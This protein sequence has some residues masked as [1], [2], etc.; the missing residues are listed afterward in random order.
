M[1]TQHLFSNRATAKLAVDVAANDTALTLVPGGGALFP[2]PGA[3]QYF[4]LVLQKGTAAT[5]LREYMVCTA[6]AGD[7]LTVTRAQEG[8]PA[9]TFN[10]GDEVS[11]VAT[12]ATFTSLVQR[13]GATLQGA[14]EVEADPTTPLGIATKAFVES[15]RVNDVPDD[16]KTYGRVFQAWLALGAAAGLPV[17]IPVN[18]G[19]TGGATVAA[20]QT[21]LYIPV[22]TFDDLP[23]ATPKYGDR[24]IRPANMTEMVW[25]PNAGG[26][27]AGI[28]INPAD[29]ASEA[30]PIPVSKGGT[31]ATT[32][33]QALINLGIAD[34]DSLRVGLNATDMYVSITAKASPGHAI[35]SITKG[36]AGAAGIYGYNGIT[37]P[38]PRWFVQLGD[39]GVESGSNAGSNFGIT[40]YNDAGAAI[41]SPFSIN[42][43]S[44]VASFGQS[45][46]FYGG[47]IFV[48]S[49]AANAVLQLDKQLAANASDIYGSIN[50]TVR[51]LLRLGQ[52]GGTD[53]FSII[54]YNDAG[55]YT[56]T[57]MQARRSDGNIQFPSPA[58]INMAGTLN[59][60]KAQA[61]GDSLYAAGPIVNTGNSVN[62][63]YSAAGGLSVGGPGYVGGQFTAG[64]GMG[65]RY[66]GGS[67]NFL[68]MGS[69]HPS[70]WNW[71]WNRSSGLLY[72]LNGASVGVF[73]IDGN[74]NTNIAGT[75]TMGASIQGKDGSG[76]A[77]GPSDFYAVNSAGYRIL[78]WAGGYC[79]RWRVAN[80]DLEWIA[81]NASV[82][83]LNYQGNIQFHGT[84]AATDG[85]I[86][87]QGNFLT[88]AT[89]GN[90]NGN[91]FSN[92]VAGSPGGMYQCVSLQH[93]P[94]VSAAVQ[95]QA[96]G[97]SFS[98]RSDGIG[99][100]PGGWQTSDRATKK[101]IKALPNGA[102]AAVMAIP[103]TE[104][105]RIAVD[106]ATGKS[107]HQVGWVAQD[108]QPVFARAVHT[109]RDWQ[110]LPPLEE[111]G[112][113]R[114]E[115][116]GNK[117]A[118]DP[119]AMTA[120][121]WKAV[122]ELNNR[123]N[124]LLEPA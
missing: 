48:H 44:G 80:G 56:E 65:F 122:Q 69:A 89:F 123:V 52:G 40:R 107:L 24:W 116:R 81:N 97:Q 82:A 74:G 101:N 29:A 30:Y 37:T 2:P 22:T 50:G 76:V 18:A 49:N 23:P 57:V 121:L 51:W 119:I 25:A 19:G 60:T 100:A 28:W 46:N 77:F 6:V 117:L 83:L 78:N 64:G 53:D 31:G 33:K 63:F 113:P 115:D 99:I 11:L 43:A 41:D 67:A 39:G 85:Q 73:N 84:V 4:R 58:G 34:H 91:L 27:G 20:A 35:L 120:L 7:V 21:N 9:G 32:V 71:Q 47:S 94:G 96:G 112:E 59:I 54:R 102:L 98:F 55:V 66:D 79:M 26:G 114:L 124:Q 42:R 14:L 16:G 88:C 95:I 1:T 105:D 15:G 72:W 92:I 106:Q 118:I 87:M 17:P 13:V 45:V 61:S 90:S 38:L 104:W 93:Q 109:Y 62:A 8:T 10:V 86:S 12:A 36:G 103:A 110:A 111:G 3:N 5:D 108:V 68:S 70:N 75:L